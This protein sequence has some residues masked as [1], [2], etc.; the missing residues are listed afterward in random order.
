MSIFDYFKKKAEQIEEAENIGKIAS[1]TAVDV[2]KKLSGTEIR[3]KQKL[4]DNLVV[5]SNASGGAGASTLLSNVAHLASKEGLK[6]LVIDLNIMFPI[7]HTYFGIKQ[8]TKKPDLVSYLLGRDSLGDCIDNTNIINL[9]YCNNRNLVDSINCE[10]DKVLLNMKEA[11]QRLRGLYDLI[12]VDAPMK[13]EHTL[14]NHLF[15]VCDQLY[16]VW[17]EGI[18]SI[19]NTEKIRRNMALSGIDAYTKLRVILNKRTNIHYSKYPF[20]KLNLECTEIIPFD[21]DIIDS[22]LRSQVFCDK[23]ESSSENA[24][25]FYKKLVSLTDKILKNGGLVK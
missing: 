15:Y 12:L 10:D 13:I 1:D 24:T 11:I 8:S 14:V 2:I 20:E 6:V 9:L 16:L 3:R 21:T 23:G 22:S 4:I 25:I 18:S 19:A 5:F 7:Q 17:D